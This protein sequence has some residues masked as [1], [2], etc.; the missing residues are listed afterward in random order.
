MNNKVSVIVNSCDKYKSVWKPFF[1]LFKKHWKDCPYQVYLNTETLT[2]NDDALNIK[3]ITC[4]QKLSWSLR[5]KKALQKIKSKYVIF[6][7][8]DFFFLED[9]DQNE[10]N[11]A[12]S[13]MEADSK[14]SVIDFEYVE[15]ISAKPSA[16][17]GYEER[18]K[19]A[20]YLLNCQAALWRRK[21]L[22]K[23]LSPYEDPWQFEIYGS[24]RAALYS[25]KFLRRGKETAKPFVYNISVETGYGLYGGK[26]LLSNKEFFEKNRITVD[27][28]ELG[29][30]EN[31]YVELKCQPPKITF[32][33]KVLYFLYGGGPVPRLNI[34]EQ[35]VLLFRSPKQFAKMIK[36][37]IK[38]LLKKTK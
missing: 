27:L 34:W 7:L 26:W 3:T 18:E 20:M 24:A 29:F 19:G 28:E 1:T 9:V 38:F 37:K 2:Y 14:I 15:R 13:I 8:E 23:F 6:L 32:K 22:I 4:S 12:V 11:R 36:N 35:I 5:L 31:K 10:I 33:E 21:D 16:F 25:R 17:N 30:T